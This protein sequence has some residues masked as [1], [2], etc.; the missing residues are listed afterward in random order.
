MLWLNLEPL[1]KT[2]HTAHSN[3]SHVTV[4]PPVPESLFPVLPY[5]NTS[6]VT[7]KPVIFQV[8]QRFSRIQIHP[9]LRLNRLYGDFMDWYVKFKYIPC[10]G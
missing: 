1:P 10:Y 9:M 8:F 2:F 7:V 6:H 5:S 4:K 3:T